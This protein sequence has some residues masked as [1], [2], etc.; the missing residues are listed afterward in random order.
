MLSMARP[1]RGLSLASDGDS[2]P[3][4]SFAAGDVNS[5]EQNRFAAPRLVGQIDRAAAVSPYL[6][7]ID[8]NQ[9]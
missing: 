5:S 8:S 3:V 2:A 9:R 6:V 4:E 1:H 7:N